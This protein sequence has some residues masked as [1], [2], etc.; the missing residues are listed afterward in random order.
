MHSLPVLRVSVGLMLPKLLLLLVLPTRV[1]S[2]GGGERPRELVEMAAVDK[3]IG[4]DHFLKGNMEPFGAVC[5]A[6]VRDSS[7]N[8]KL[9][10]KLGAPTKERDR[11]LFDLQL[12][13]GA[14]ID[15]EPEESLV[16]IK[17]NYAARLWELVKLEPFDKDPVHFPSK[18]GKAWKEKKVRQ[19]ML[20]HGFATVNL[21]LPNFRGKMDAFPWNKYFGRPNSRGVGLLLLSLQPDAE[22]AQFQAMRKLRPYIDKFADKFRFAVV[23]KDSERTLELRQASKLG[24]DGTIKSELILIEKPQSLIKNGG[25][26]ENLNNWHGL[27]EKYR[28]TNMT[29]EAINNFFDTYQQG[30]LPTYW[31]TSE[32]GKSDRKGAATIRLTSDSFEDLVFNGDA[33]KPVLVAFFNDHP[34]DGCRD[35]ERA[36]VVWEAF[37]RKAHQERRLQQVVIADIDQSVNEHPE[38]KIPQR[39]AQPMVVWYPPGTAKQRSKRRQVLWDMSQGWTEESLLEKFKDRVVDLAIDF[40]DDDEL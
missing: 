24:L 19:W 5:V 30:K 10:K 25:N 34:D 18:P 27:P 29:E 35:C 2:A 22:R 21:R 17:R 13:M 32:V 33:K 3:A 16:I 9:M 36:R 11:V 4:I 28:L 12:P 40:S 15:W 38:D 31:A 26:V 1:A 8:H 20:E 37:A 23:E 7:P 39:L 14:A 6:Y